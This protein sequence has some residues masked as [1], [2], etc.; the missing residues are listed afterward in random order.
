MLDDQAV[1]KYFVS[2]DDLNFT[3]LREVNMG[4]IIS[5]KSKVRSLL[6][7]D[8]RHV[9]ISKRCLTLADYSTYAFDT[10]FNFFFDPD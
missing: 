1:I 7:V 4:H 8:W 2:L 9:L 5:L 3:V 10:D 6:K